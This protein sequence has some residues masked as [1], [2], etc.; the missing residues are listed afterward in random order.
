MLSSDEI[1]YNILIEA[2]KHGNPILEHFHIQYPS[3][4][5][6]EESNSIFVAVVSSEPN[7]ELFEATEYRDLVEVLVVTKIRDYKDAVTVIKT[8]I[9]EIINIIKSN[10]E[11]FD[12]RPIVRNIAPEYNSD[13]VLNKGHI[14]VE[15]LTEIENEK[16][17][18]V[19]DKV[20]SIL[21]EDIEVEW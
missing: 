5:I 7:T 21:V 16:P 1:I 12:V 17:Q 3:R 14:M 9:H 11:D 8:T 6:A 10:E 13:F 4:K 18:D 2:Q 19:Y 20:C 15:V